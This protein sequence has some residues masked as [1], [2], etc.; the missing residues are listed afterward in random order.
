MKNKKLDNLQALSLLGEEIK[1]MM[2]KELA[3]ASFTT[4]AKGRVTAAEDGLYTIALYGTYYQVPSKAAY[5]LNDTVHV[6]VP[7]NAPENMVIIG[8]A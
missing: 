7:Q 2:K 4:L 8:K 6:L 5:A 3:A 1:K